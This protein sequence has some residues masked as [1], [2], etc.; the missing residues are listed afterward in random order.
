[1][2]WFR[3]ARGQDWVGMRIWGLG[4]TESTREDA[5]ARESE[6]RRNQD[7][8]KWPGTEKGGESGQQEQ[9]ERWQGAGVTGPGA[10]SPQGR[11]RAAP[12]PHTIREES[13]QLIS[14]RSRLQDGVWRGRAGRDC[15]VRV[16]GTPLAAGSPRRARPWRRS[17]PPVAKSVRVRGGS[18]EAP[19]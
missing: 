11:G 14:G 4:C 13:L 2:R 10:E 5:L 12:G 19:T 18:S 6:P 16:L 17:C 15:G 1:M 9:A 7:S 3:G 8:L